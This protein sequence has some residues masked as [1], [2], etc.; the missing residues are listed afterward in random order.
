[1]SHR[2]RVLRQLASRLLPRA[3][4]SLHESTLNRKY[5]GVA[6]GDRVGNGAFGNAPGWSAGCLPGRYHANSFISPIS[7]TRTAICRCN[8]G[9]SGS[10]RVRPPEPEGPGFGFQNDRHPVM[11]RRAQLVRRGGHDREA[12]YPV[13]S[14]LAA[15]VNRT[16]AS[17]SSARRRNPS[18]SMW[19]RRMPSTSAPRINPAA[20]NTIGPLMRERSIRPAIGC[21]SGGTRPASRRFRTSLACLPQ[22]VA[23]V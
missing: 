11:Q 9:L 22:R 5:R 21:R 12:A 10:S 3:R 4:T 2:R 16:I 19:M 18:P 15:S 14:E 23:R 8:S 6:R 17:V 1:V 7:I 20:V 13:K